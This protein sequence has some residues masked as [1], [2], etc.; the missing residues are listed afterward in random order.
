M[1]LTATVNIKTL[2]IQRKQLEKNLC[3]ILYLHL[4]FTIALLFTTKVTVWCIKYL[5][6]FHMKEYDFETLLGRFLKINEAF[7][8]SY[9][10]EWE[11]NWGSK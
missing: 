6:F 5:A 8:N 4:F 2:F 9:N 10:F 1:F 7:K 11:K 3:F